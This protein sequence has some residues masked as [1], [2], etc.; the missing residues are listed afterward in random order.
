VSS[1]F[2]YAH[3][4]LPEWHVLGEVARRS[5]C[6]ILLD[7]NNVYVS[8]HNHG[9][10][11]VR[12]LHGVPVGAVRE[13]HLA[14]H[15][16]NA[17]PGG[18]LLIDTHSRPVC[19]AVWAL[20]GAA[21]ERFGPVPTLIEWDSDLPPLDTLLAEAATAD[22]WLDAARAPRTRRSAQRTRETAD[23]IAG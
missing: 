22:A 15:V 9:F 20:Y 6:G 2:E 10:D 4:T 18:A 8:A 11:A 13:M 7:V 23:A 3:S 14:G 17:V 19:D 5:G 21:L 12:Y 1:Y 16:R